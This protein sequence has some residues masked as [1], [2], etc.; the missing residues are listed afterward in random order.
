[1]APGS[2]RTAPLG[3][4]NA[5]WASGAATFES[6]SRSRPALTLRTA[7]ATITRDDEEETVKV[8]GSPAVLL[9]VEGGD[10]GGIGRY[11]VDLAGLLGT[12][13]VV[14]CLCDYPCAS[15]GG[16]WLA[17]QCRTR[18]VPL[19]TIPMP[20]KGWRDG[21]RGL[22]GLW[23]RAGRPLVHVNGRRGNSLAIIA[24]VSVPGFRYVT[25]AHGI[26]GL[27]GRRNAAYRLVDLAACQAAEA[28]IAVS[29]DTGR[30]LVRAGSPRR[31]TRV[32]PNALAESDLRNLCGVADERRSGSDNGT[33]LR[34]GFLGR[35]SPEKGTH[36][37]LD[38]ARRLNEVAPTAK[39]AIAGDG[40]DREWFLRESRTLRA[41]GFMSWHGVSDDATSFLRQVD[42]LLMPS[43]NEG[44]PYVLL[45]AM[46]AG[47]AVVAFDVGGIAEVISDPSLGVLVR[48]GDVDGLVAQLARLGDA[49]GLAISI[50]RAASAHVR[51]Q[52]S[53]RSRMPLL[54]RA[55]D[56][57]P[58]TVRAAGSG[59]DEEERK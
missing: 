29:V 9:V 23:K 57:D 26:L 37:L 5:D 12:Q 52:F 17:G 34:I 22:V 21:L 11:C 16:C 30:R 20:P 53:L 51:E 25:T 8:I 18:G 15:A 6:R 4:W 14:V 58:A 1:V 48:P 46:A 19:L 28:V 24:R 41:S 45:E 59:P 10:S 42:V 13:A 33:S 56:L 54:L 47:C 50:G 35:L 27:H 3:G 40:P 38:V 31:K 36:E 2:G 49:P 39:F 55:Y 7:Q 44:M 32:V 43:H